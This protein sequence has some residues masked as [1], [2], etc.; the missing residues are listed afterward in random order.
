MLVEIFA[1]IYAFGLV[2]CPF[3]IK[4]HNVQAVS[5]IM[6]LVRALFGRLLNVVDLR[7][8]RF[9]GWWKLYVC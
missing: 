1:I 4:C 8:E 5:Q 2:L 6:L 7:N 3:D 9:G